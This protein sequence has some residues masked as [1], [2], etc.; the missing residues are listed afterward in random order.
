MSTPSY[1][2]HN[3]RWQMALNIPL[4]KTNTVQRA[5]SFLGPKIL[6]KVSNSIESVKLQLLLHMLSRDKF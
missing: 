1:N 4:Q 6:T 3:T 2:R 5:L